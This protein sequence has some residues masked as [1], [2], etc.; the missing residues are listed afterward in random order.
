M[1]GIDMSSI[2]KADPG[3]LYRVEVSFKPEYA[4]YECTETSSDVEEDTYDDYYYE[5]DYYEESYSEAKAENEDEREEQY[6]D[7]RIY[8]WRNRVYNWEEEDNPC[9]P[10]FYS[11]D[12]FLNANILGS[13]LGIIVKKGKDNSYMFA[14][15]DIVTTTP[16]ANTEIK[17][18][19]YQKQVIASANTDATGIARMN[20]KGHAVYAVAKKGSNYSYMKLEDGYSLSMSKFNISGRHLEKGL[21]LSLIHI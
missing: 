19:N 10:A 14:A 11:E 2:F 12:R 8:R 7:N 6:W 5:E 9:H 17:L 3:S 20:P 16:E 1:H 15:S 18:Y 4:L 21:K 13:D